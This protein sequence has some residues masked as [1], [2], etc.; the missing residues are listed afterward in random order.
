MDIERVKVVLLGP[1][2]AG[3]SSLLFTYITGGLTN[4][5]DPTVGAS[6]MSKSLT[7][8]GKTIR[9]DI[10]DTAGQE[11]YNT[12]SKMYCR[13]TRAVILVC[14]ASESDPAVKLQYWTELINSEELE[15]DAKIFIVANKI[16]KLKEDS[17]V[18]EEIQKIAEKMSAVVF[19]TSCKEN[20]GVHEMFLQ[21]AQTFAVSSKR[22]SDNT[23]IS[24]NSARHSQAL[25]S[26][27][28]QRKKCC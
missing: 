16:D 4:T 9:L 26:R 27:A 13:G 21:I 15:K 7:A 10:W 22:L 24:I 28:K 1:T 8:N 20:I 6:F 12:F 17:N 25:E 11:R 5:I 23:R 19:L 18:Q 3:K 2:N 14:D